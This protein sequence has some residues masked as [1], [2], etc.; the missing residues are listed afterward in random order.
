MPKGGQRP[1]AGRPPGSINKNEDPQAIPT[2]PDP[3][4]LSFSELEAKTRAR[5]NAILDKQFLNKDDSIALTAL[6]KFL[7]FF[8]SKSPMQLNVDSNV[9]IDLDEILGKLNLARSNPPA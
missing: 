7:E 2:N 4:S 1:G 6:S 9:K 5:I 3:S 8:K